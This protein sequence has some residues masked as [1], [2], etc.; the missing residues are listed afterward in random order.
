MLSLASTE[1]ERDKEHQK[2]KYI[3]HNLTR[4]IELE[5]SCGNAEYILKLHTCSCCIPSEC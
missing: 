4:V 1:L 2:H 3:K 5:K